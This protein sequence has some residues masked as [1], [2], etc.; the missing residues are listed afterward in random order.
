MENEQAKRKH[1]E[2]LKQIVPQQKC[3]L[4]VINR[5]LDEVLAIP[6]S[7]LRQPK[8]YGAARKIL[9]VVT[10]YN[11]N[12]PSGFFFNYSNHL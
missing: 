8:S 4:N 6:Q 9:P 7:E 2:E 1:L 12:N 3:P 11:Q 10:T 5:G